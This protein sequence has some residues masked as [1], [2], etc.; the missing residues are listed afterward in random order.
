MKRLAAL[1]AVA[2]RE[3]DS[4]FGRGAATREC[5]QFVAIF[6]WLLCLL[7]G[8]LAIAVAVEG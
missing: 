7:A 4:E 1:I 5:Q 3:F 2:V 6:P 8:L